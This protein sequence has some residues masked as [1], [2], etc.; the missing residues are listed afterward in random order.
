[1]T[2]RIQYT[3]DAI[4]YLL[5]TEMGGRRTAVKNFYRPNFNFN[6]EQY[7]CGE[8]RFK[9]NIEWI[10]PGQS[11][12]ATIVMIPASF[13]PPDIGPNYAFQISG[14]TK[15]VGTGLIRDVLER[16]VITEDEGT[17]V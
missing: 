16:A 15:V 8:V 6:T 2:D 4:I 9:N 7:F 17:F 10:A 5:P 12:E 11:V 14:G 13:I 1:M 3:F